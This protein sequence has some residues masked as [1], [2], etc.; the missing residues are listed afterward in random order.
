ML[1]ELQLLFIL[2]LIFSPR[3]LN[4]L[5]NKLKLY[6]RKHNMPRYIFLIRHGESEANIDQKIHQ[7][8]PD[9]KVQLTTL[10]KE[11][12]DKAAI[13]LKEFMTINKL[14]PKQC[15]MWISPHD[16]ARQTA[17][18]VI[19]ETGITLIR[20]EPR[21]REQDFGNFHD[22]A[23]K[24]MKVR[25]NYGK[26]YYR[27]DNGEAGADVYDRVST[28]METL[29]RDMDT[30]NFQSMCLV[31][32]GLTCRLFLMRFLRWP[33]ELFETIP[34]LNNAEMIVLK[35]N[36]NTGRYGLH[37]DSSTPITPFSKWYRSL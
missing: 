26:F 24:E 4:T 36:T 13:Y 32:H 10:G 29:Y 35:F 8:V 33:V 31:S 20:E 9:N 34:N 25:D 2:L 3:L 1:F 11:Q 28:F 7:H 19:I 21:I 37:I 5:L 14:N 15:K 18:R 22:V 12:A 16:R 27:F 17:A 23:E 30:G 6:L